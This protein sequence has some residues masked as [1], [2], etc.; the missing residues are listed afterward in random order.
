TGVILSAVYLLW[1]LQRVLFGEITKKDNAEL[2]EMNWREK[3][4]LIP[5][6]IMAIVMGVGPMI[7]LRGTEKSVNSIRESVQSIVRR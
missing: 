4:A 5:L 2:E 3:T 7:F 6:V 1:M